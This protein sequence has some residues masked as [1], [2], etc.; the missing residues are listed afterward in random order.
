MKVIDLL[1]KIANKECLPD[2]IKIE[3]VNSIN[4]HNCYY[5]FSPI[6]ESYINDD[7]TL[8]QN[9]TNL[10]TLLDLKIEIIEDKRLVSNYD[11]SKSDDMEEIKLKVEYNDNSAYIT[12]DGKTYDLSLSKQDYGYFTIKEII[13]EPIDI[14]VI[15]KTKNIAISYGEY[16]KFKKQ[17]HMLD[18]I[19]GLVNKYEIA[20]YA[21]TCENNFVEFLEAVSDIVKE[22]D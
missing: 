1:N 7:N 19:K 10:A 18:T 6:F 16:M 20:Y 22:E 21:E 4:E 12:L 8:I 3:C 9:A 15:I 13:Y 5:H 11:I 2:K 17:E 14:Y